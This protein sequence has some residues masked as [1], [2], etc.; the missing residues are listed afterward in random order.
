[1]R[2]EV[3]CTLFMHVMSKSKDKEGNVCVF[4]SFINVESTNV[5]VIVDV[6]G[7]EIRGLKYASN[8]SK[9]SGL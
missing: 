6:V 4:A 1:M 5:R 9:W 8:I 3:Y 7:D 2:V